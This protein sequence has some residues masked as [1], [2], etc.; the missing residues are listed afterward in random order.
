M[1]ITTKEIT[2][3]LWPQLE[4]LFGSNGACGGCWCQAWRI[5]KG[6][7]WLDVKGIKAKTRL[8]KGVYNG[9]TYGILAFDNEIPAGWC[10][11]GPRNSF[12]RINRAPTLKCD[13]ASRVWSLPCFFVPRVYRGKG[14]ATAMLSHAL[15]VITRQGVEIAE[16]YP[17]KPDK[18]GLYIAAFSWTGT[19]SLFANAGFIVAGNPDGSKQR[20]RK[21]LQ[22]DKHP[23]DK[24][25]RD[26]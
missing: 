17:T 11:F 20:V 10:T 16:G 18:N 3:K 13:D 24:D 9:T 22:K 19:R 2:P 21:F 23:T 12:S 7:H 25:I 4:Q 14:I 6:E 5:E 15:K 8:R 26:R 1:P